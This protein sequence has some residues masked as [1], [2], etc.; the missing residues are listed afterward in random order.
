M[1]GGPPFWLWWQ[2][3][4]TIWFAGRRQWLW[5]AFFAALV[6]VNALCAIGIVMIKRC[7]PSGDTK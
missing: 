3:L 6:I 4:L 5:C 1:I 2:V 7:W